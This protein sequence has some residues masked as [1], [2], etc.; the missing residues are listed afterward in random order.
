VPASYPEETFY[1]KIG[2]MKDPH[3]EK[4]RHNPNNYVDHWLFTHTDSI[5]GRTL[6]VTHEF[7]TV[8]P[9]VATKPF[10]D[11]FNA[12]AWEAPGFKHGF[13]ES[14]V[15]EQQRQNYY[16]KLSDWISNEG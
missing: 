12:D 9:P 2:A 15:T 10:T 3:S 16:K 13:R 8:C 4:Y 14:H 11:A 1:T 7:D 6:V 5:K